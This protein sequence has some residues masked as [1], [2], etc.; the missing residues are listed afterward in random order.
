MEK[1]H[2]LRV[3]RNSCPD[4][5]EA[6]LD[7]IANKLLSVENP[8]IG[9]VDSYN[10]AQ[11]QDYSRSALYANLADVEQRISATA[12]AEANRRIYE[13]YFMNSHNEYNNWTYSVRNIGTPRT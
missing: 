8:T 10:A 13:E 12:R 3:L 7:I 1:T 4:K 11:N 2:I 5:D 9:T 6:E